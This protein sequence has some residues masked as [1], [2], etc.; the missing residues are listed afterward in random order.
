MSAARVP[1]ARDAPARSVYA[2][3]RHGSWVITLVATAVSTYALDAFAIVVGALLAASGSS[4]G[5]TGRRCSPSW[6]PPTR[7]GAPACAS[8]S[9]RTGRCSSRHRREHEHPLQGRARHRAGSDTR[10]RACAASRHRRGYVL[11]ELAKEVPYYASATGAVLVSDTVSASEAI[12]FLAGTNLGAA[13]IRVRSRTRDAGLPA[14]WDSSHGVRTARHRPAASRP[15]LPPF[16]P[17]CDRRDMQ[18]AA[19]SQV[20]NAGDLRECGAGGGP[21]RRRPH[22]CPLVEQQRALVDAA[23]RALQAQRRSALAAG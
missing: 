7:S 23:A 16:R 12:V 18:A 20:L 3:R 4:P 10:A 6:P 19:R 2:G 17:R 21:D 8:I 1:S 5:S 11:T 15:C 13:P 14:A 9:R 22:A